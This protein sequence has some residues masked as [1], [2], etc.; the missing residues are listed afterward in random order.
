[1]S[2]EPLLKT[3]SCKHVFVTL[4]VSLPLVICLLF[5]E[6][7]N[8]FN[9]VCSSSSPPLPSPQGQMPV[10]A[11]LSVL[12]SPPDHT[13]LV[14]PTHFQPVA[15]LTSGMLQYKLCPTPSS[16]TWPLYI[17]PPKAVVLTPASSPPGSFR[18]SSWPWFSLYVQ[19]DYLF[20]GSL[21]IAPLSRRIVLGLNSL[22]LFEHGVSLGRLGIPSS[23]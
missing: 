12:K 14:S 10:A 5:S 16:R 8:Y 9:G 18:Q 6:M 23:V 4:G 15:L 19:Q 17:E 1:M 20:P 22:Q 3:G 11:T 2:H 13:W 7:R 21:S